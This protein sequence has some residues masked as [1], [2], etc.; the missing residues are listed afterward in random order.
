M[1]F[2]V[3]SF[4]LLT[5]V[6]LSCTKTLDVEP[7]YSLDASASFK[8]IDD[9]DFALI[10]AYSAFRNNNYYG[11]SDAFSSAYSLLPDFLSD[12][13]VETNE[14][15]GN[16]EV[17]SQWFFAADEPQVEA[18]WLAAYNIIAKSN[19]I[20]SNNIDQFS[21]KNGGAVNR[22]KGQALAIR[23]WVHFDILR[24]WVD[25]YDRNSTKPGIP[26]ITQFNY[27]QKPSRGNVKQTYDQIEKDLRDARNLLSNTDRDV[28][29]NGGRAYIDT[30][31][32]DGMMARAFLYSNQM[33]SAIQYASYVINA[34]PLAQPDDFKNI[35]TDASISEVLWACDF[36]AGQGGPGTEAFDPSTNRSQYGP[37]PGLLALYDPA[38]DIRYPVYFQ[39]Y[40]SGNGSR[41]VFTKYLAKQPQLARPD[42]VVNFKVLRTGEMY[43]VRAEA[44]ARKG[45]AFEQQALDDL[46]TL[47]LARINGYTPIS[48]SGS[49]LLDEIA[50]ERRRELVGEGHRFFDLKRTTRTV[51]RTNCANFCSIGPSD[52]VWTW[53]IPQS[54]IDANP[55]ILPQNPG[56]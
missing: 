39:D 18:T 29:Q 6:F 44:F 56:Y 22:I 4:F 11:S 17:F 15:L 30:L 10:G 24:Y 34:L 52:R 5:T 35:W 1:N 20:L 41:I 42:G 51:Q 27:K 54:E 45:A 55:T 43:L 46:N 40:P 53:P 50:I 47:R 19:L 21:A 28:N 36:E 14:S 3:I 33:D 48:V 37:D 38:N 13:L 25:D 2:R 23:G 7:S 49:Q 26:Y 32:I 8:S 12:N 16:E 31:A 9:F